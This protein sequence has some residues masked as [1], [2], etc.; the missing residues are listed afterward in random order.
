MIEPEV[1]ATRP[2]LLC[3]FADDIA[4]LSNLLQQAQLLTR[5]ENSS[6]D[7]GLHINTTETE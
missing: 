7:I 3:D 6:K 4:L 1:G 5:V 2:K